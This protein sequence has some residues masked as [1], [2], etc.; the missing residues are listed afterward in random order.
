MIQKWTCPICN[1]IIRL[2]NIKLPI[3]CRCGNIYT[4]IEIIQE[5]GIIIKN[6]SQPLDRKL[7]DQRLKIC[8]ECP[9]I[10]DHHIVGL[11]CTHKQCDCGK[12]EQDIVEIID[13]KFNGGLVHKAKYGRCPDNRW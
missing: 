3:Y 13:R 12:G 2:E 10:R 1:K 8:L 7:V 9:Y 6:E 5:S 11:R 4:E